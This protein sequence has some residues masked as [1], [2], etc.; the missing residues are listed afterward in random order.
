MQ[1]ADHR[2]T[3]LSARVSILCSAMQ[4]RMIRQNFTVKVRIAG[5]SS[6]PF[7]SLLDDFIGTS[8]PNVRSDDKYL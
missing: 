5:A 8:R 1:R 4:S 6:D 7:R 3:L 2:P